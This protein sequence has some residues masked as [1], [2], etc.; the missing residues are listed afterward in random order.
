MNKQRHEGTK[1]RRHGVGAST[2]PGSSHPHFPVRRAFTLTEL[3]VAV[4]VLIVVIIATSKIFGTASKVT[5]MGQGVQSLLQEAAAIERQIRQDIS[6]LT[7][8]G[9]F[10][11]HSVSVR[12]DVHF[13]ATT[14]LLDP[15]QAPDALVRCDQLMFF[16]NGLQS[17]QA[18]RSGQGTNHKGQG[19]SSRVLYSHGFQLVNA[20]GGRQITNTQFTSHDANIPFV[21]ANAIYTWNNQIP[22][23][24]PDSLP[25]PGVAPTAY[26]T[27]VAMTGT[28][29]Q[30]SHTV[31]PVDYA[32]IV[33][34]GAPTSIN[35]VQPIT[36]QWLMVREAI[37]LADDESN[38]ATATN[39]VVFLDSNRELYS[40]FPVGNVVK[41]AIRKGRVDAAA[42]QLSDVREQVLFVNP[43]NA[44]RANWMEPTVSNSQRGRIMRAMYY[45]RAE[46]KA[47]SMSRPDQALT[48]N[49]LSAGCSSFRVDW[50]YA[51]G[52]GQAT[53]SAGTNYAGVF[54]DSLVEQPW[55][56]LQDLSRGVYNYGE[57]NAG[58]AAP[59]CPY[60]QG[61]FNQA[62][63]IQADAIETFFSGAQ[64]PSGVQDYWAVFGYN[65]NTPLDPSTGQP[66]VFAPPLVPSAYTP[67]PT[68]LRITMTLHD[69][70]GKI[71]GGREFQFVVDLPRRVN[72]HQ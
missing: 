24:F 48:D 17:I 35:A 51:A 40:I 39:K 71:E 53:N 19:T 18:F 28:V 26:S 38:A 37:V 64:I 2:S 63:T 72:V 29:F 21:A 47:P 22:P 5:G 62:M 59:N 32:N 52:T 3:L 54:A 14:P 23:W 13:N 50:T 7:G 11:I 46:R 10:V 65:Q 33:L 16:S 67:L 69:P 20:V 9:F 36:R 1:A 15:N 56:G 49:V 25:R 6:R 70:E 31:A 30:N 27:N 4:V 44:T 41:S 57:R 43:L 42:E 45:P 58:G 55:F 66:W 8:E 60:A 61:T 34:A 12:N 68:A